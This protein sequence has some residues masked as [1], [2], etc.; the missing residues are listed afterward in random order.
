MT[1]ADLVKV[2]IYKHE[3]LFYLLISLYCFISINTSLYMRKCW[4]FCYYMSAIS[5]LILVIASIYEVVHIDMLV[6]KLSDAII[7]II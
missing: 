3:W 5:S 4:K 7:D 1:V 6:L 2:S